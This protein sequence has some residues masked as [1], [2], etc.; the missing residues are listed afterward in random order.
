VPQSFP[1]CLAC[2]HK[3]DDWACK[4]F[5]SGIHKDILRAEDDHRK[6]RSGDGGTTFTRNPK[7]PMP[8]GFR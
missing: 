5:P 2:L 7:M 1:I 8:P 6:P 3:R 4:A